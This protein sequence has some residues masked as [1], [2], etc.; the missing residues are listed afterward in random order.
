[1]ASPSDDFVHLRS[2]SAG[3]Q[4]EQIAS[5]LPAKKVQE[6]RM[7]DFRRFAQLQEMLRVSCTC[8]R[9][10]T[11]RRFDALAK[12]APDLAEAC[13]ELQ[14]AN[15]L[16]DLGQHVHGMESLVQRIQAKEKLRIIFIGPLKAGKS[17][18]INLLL[19]SCLPDCEMLLPVDNKAATN[20]IWKV[21]STTERHACVYLNDV[22]Q[23]EWLLDDLKPEVLRADMAEFLEEKFARDANPSGHGEICIQLPLDLLNPF[24]C[25]YSLVDTP[26]F[27]ESEEYAKLVQRFLQDHSHIACMVCPL[28][29]GTAKPEHTQQML[30]L[31]PYSKTFWVLTRYDMAMN[32]KPGK[33]QK[34]TSKRQA[35]DSL[36]SQF[37]RDIGSS[38]ARIFLHAGGLLQDPED[39]SNEVLQKYL[40]LEEATSWLRDIQNHVKEIFMLLQQE[41][42]VLSNQSQTAMHRTAELT[43]EYRKRLETSQG[44]VAASDFYAQEMQ[45]AAEDAAGDLEREIRQE[46][47]AVRNDKLQELCTSAGDEV[48]QEGGPSRWVRHQ[49]IEKL[50]SKL[51]P[52]IEKEMQSRLDA[53]MMRAQEKTLQV[54]LRLLTRAGLDASKAGETSSQSEVI[55]PGTGHLRGRYP[56]ESVTMLTVT[57]LS[58]GRLAATEAGIAALGSF[59]V[60][61]T[62]LQLA[63]V[64]GAAIAGIALLGLGT[65]YALEAHPFWTRETANA[66]VVAEI[67]R[68]NHWSILSQAASA[69]G[70]SQLLYSATR[71]R[72]KFS[73]LLLT[74][75]ASAEV[76]SSLF[77]DLTLLEQVKAKLNS[78]C[79]DIEQFMEAE[80]LG[81]RASRDFSTCSFKVVQR[82]WLSIV[83]QTSP[84]VEENA[85]TDAV[86]GDILASLLALRTEAL[87]KSQ[88]LREAQH[89]VGIFRRLFPD[90]TLPLVYDVAVDVLLSFLENK[91]RQEMVP[92][93]SFCNA[94]LKQQDPKNP[95]VPLMLQ[96]WYLCV[97]ASFVPTPGEQERKRDVNTMDMLLGA[98]ESFANSQL[99]GQPNWNAHVAANF[100]L[101][102]EM[103]PAEV[104]TRQNEIWESYLTL[105]HRFVACLLNSVRELLEALPARDMEMDIIGPPTSWMQ[106]R[107]PLFLFHWRLLILEVRSRRSGTTIITF[108]FE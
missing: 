40:P 8:M 72:Y 5:L 101:V 99:Q 22:L 83:D 94:E 30:A 36:V 14:S 80:A 38:S 25:H 54:A 71:F 79:Q 42:T 53:A 100:S 58:I 35:A 106:K 77:P 86:A 107:E 69:R 66:E 39:D 74:N 105:C 10:F 104:E 67:Q 98:I 92:R 34:D 28:T 27:T 91:D 45:T 97:V 85:R 102:K 18:L 57:A 64:V 6:P 52:K 60:T 95:E 81:E 32:L 3:T 17:S 7:A 19:S 41:Q 61:A 31:N 51:V 2:T 49:Y 4:W 44:T 82:D 16:L 37:R 15:S 48:N 26:G 1:M 46:I 93:V 33:K 13:K 96:I 103:S 108:H 90:L 24:G 65:K 56:V 29:E 21:E 63:G 75:G 88:M 78:C 43:D 70:K 50:L 59:G 68:A 62:S 84:Y 73:E 87:V 12:E 11:R 47:D 76:L 9:E 23:K 89:T 20:C 55:T